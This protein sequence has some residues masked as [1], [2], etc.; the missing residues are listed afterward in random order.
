MPPANP[1][2]ITDE[3]QVA[4]QFTP[5]FDQWIVTYSDGTQYLEVRDQFGGVVSRSKIVKDQPASSRRRTTT[6]STAP[7]QPPTAQPPI[8][9]PTTQPATARTTGQPTQP[10]TATGPA[11]TTTTTAPVR[12]RTPATT[13][14]PS[15][16]T[17]TSQTPGRGFTETARPAPKLGDVMAGPDRVLADGGAVVN[18]R[19]IPPGFSLG[20]VSA[21]QNR[22]GTGGG[23]GGTGGGTTTPPAATVP[24]DWE[25]AAQEIYGGYYAVIKSVPEIS[26]LLQRA[27]TEGWSDAKFDYELRQTAWFKTTSDSARQWDIAKQTDPAAAQQQIDTRIAGVREKALV[28]GVRL[29]DESVANLAE[30][31]IRGGWTEQ[32]LD[33]AIGAEALKSTAGVSQL[34]TGYIGQTLKQTA[35]NY[36][37]TL[38]DTTFNE[39]VNKVATGQENEQSFQQYTLQLAKNLYPGIVGQLESGQTFQQI[40]DPY[41]QLASRT[42]EMNAD[43]V[44][45][46]DPKWAKAVTYV[47]DKGEQRPMNYNEWAAYL[48]QE[49]SFGY[50]FTTEAKNRAY[51]ITNDLANLFGKV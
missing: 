28:L 22:G 46:T 23:I 39:W 48:R 8:A 27:V 19:Y 20:G 7:Q 18:G 14:A 32:I 6:T 42:L 5:G 1:P 9:T 37:I 2:S 26:N 35:S 17:A 4:G 10:P 44:D 11:T 38:S 16:T 34:R 41:R 47:T 13:T 49:R 33:N 3:I 43:T 45:F 25:Q 24:A 51:Q 21:D 40:V 31:S 36:G 15:P 12:T 50:E 30:S 29:S